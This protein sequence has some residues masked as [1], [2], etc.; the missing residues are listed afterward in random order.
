[1][2]EKEYVKV[3]FEDKRFRFRVKKPNE[4]SREIVLDGPEA[5][6]VFKQLNTLINT[7]PRS[8]DDRMSLEKGE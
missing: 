8:E 4:A 1:M 7:R 5:R 6:E 3:S 2:N